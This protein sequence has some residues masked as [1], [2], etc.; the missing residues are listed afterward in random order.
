MLVIVLCAFGGAGIADLSADRAKPGREITSA[1]HKPRGER[2]KIG[3]IAVELNATRHHLH[4]RL[5]QAFR[6][7]MLA[8][9]RAGDAG[10]NATLVFLL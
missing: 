10:M 7:A 2:A 8:S 9:D 3:A 6:C 1:R 5:V 4:V